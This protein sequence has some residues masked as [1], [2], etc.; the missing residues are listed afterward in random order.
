MAWL[1]VGLFFGFALAPNVP[2]LAISLDV[3]RSLLDPAR[4]LLLRHAK[5][6]ISPGKVPAA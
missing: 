2:E 6:W 1:G 3:V 4:S 5:S